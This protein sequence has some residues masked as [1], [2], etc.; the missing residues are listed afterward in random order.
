[1]AYV[2]GGSSGI[3][4]ALAR[5]LLRHRVTTVI[6]AR[7][8]ERLEESLD[9]LH[10]VGRGVGAEVGTR[11]GAESLDVSDRE[12]VG[13]AFDRAESVYGTPTIVIHAAGIADPDHF[14]ALTPDRYQKQLEVNLTGTWNVLHC[15]A[16]SMRRHGKRPCHILTV[17]SLAGII[18]V[19]GYT[20]YGATKFGVLGLSLALRQELHREGIY[21]SV[22]APPDVD[23]PQLAEESA[24]KP[25][26]TSAI[27][28]SQPL[29][30]E[31]V[32]RYALRNLFR[33]R[34]LI[35]PG[36]R[37]RFEAFAYRM[38]PRLVERFVLKR[39][40]GVQRE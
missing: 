10:S 20:A 1:M 14:A 4:F 16:A 24:T 40:Q 35:I 27:S 3:G 15:A 19:Y 2:T 11:V 5:E 12:S 17:S 31:R 34:P 9:L 36:I 33:R 38:A 21:V 26:E 39:I 6:F 32:A 29:D 22:L 28:R 25:A 7:N 8:R 30:P 37:A 23:T 13:A 18:P